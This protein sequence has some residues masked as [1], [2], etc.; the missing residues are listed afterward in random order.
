ME[1]PR[2]IRY[3]LA[4]TLWGT[5]LLAFAVAGIGLTLYQNLTLEGRARQAMEPYVRLISVGTDSAVAF[6][7]PVRAKQILDTLRANPQILSAAIILED[8]RILA[9]YSNKSDVSPRPDTK[10]DEG[11]YLNGHTV[12]LLEKLPYDAHFRLVMSL[13]QLD[14]QMH[15]TFW[16]FGAGGILLVA[17]T[18][19]LLAVL[20][21]AII[22]PMAALAEAAEWVRTQADYDCSVPSAGN[23]E[24]AQLGQSFNAMLEAVRVREQELRRVSLF[25]RTL[26]DHAAY[27]IISATPDGVVNSFNPSAERLTGYT[28]AEVLGKTTP[29]LWHDPEEVARHAH[30]LSTE[31]GEPIEPGFE[32]FAARARQNMVE[33]TEW[34]FIRKDG[35]RV[36]V[37]LSVTALRDEQGNLTGFVG[38]VRDLS[39]R[40]QADEELRRSQAALREAQRIGEIGGWEWDS[41]QDRFWWSEEFRRLFGITPEALPPNYAE[42]L[43]SFVPES[44]AR[45]DAAVKAALTSGQA[46][47]LD[48]ELA[49]PTSATRWIAVRGEVKRDEDGAICGLRGTAQNITERK[50]AEEEIRQLNETLENRVEERTSELGTKNAELERLNKIFV[51]RE[52]RMA[53][54]KKRIKELEKTDL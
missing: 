44:A 45:L 50:R 1:R 17:V 28:A 9:S 40:K 29:L 52:L 16:L 6:E 36:P 24:V 53:E 8:G 54:L 46:Y 49:E 43:E 7:D 11:I 4:L 22:S 13:E 15:Q 37:L 42:H 30:E 18:L 26:L 32:V 35:T 3:K 38:L 33:E 27:A 25:Q 5:T 34:T 10:R 12:E 19:S 20:K 31:Q 41:R 51:G 39:E 23:D 2:S 48:L 21:R 47:E 14:R